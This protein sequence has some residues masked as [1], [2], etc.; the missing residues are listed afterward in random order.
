[1]LY[2]TVIVWWIQQ[3]PFYWPEMAERYL[4]IHF[5]AEKGLILNYTNMLLQFL[6]Q[7]HE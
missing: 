7:L 6:V 1:M 5:F 2:K 3:N 4:S